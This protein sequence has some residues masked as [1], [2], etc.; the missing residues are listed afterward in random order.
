MNSK[1]TSVLIVDD[2]P[3]NLEVLIEQLE[4]TGFNVSVVPNGEEALELAN[5]I[6][7]DIILLDVLRQGMDGFETCRHLKQLPAF[8]DI[9]IIFISKSFSWH[10]KMP[11]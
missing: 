5:K 8:Q 2:T 11:P 6:I 3:E 7:P 10:K 1:P 9:P 4:N